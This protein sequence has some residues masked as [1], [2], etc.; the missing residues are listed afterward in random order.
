MIFC[1]NSIAIFF[2]KNNE[3][4]S[5]SKYINIKLFSMRKKIKKHKVSIKHISIELMIA[6]LMAKSLPVKK[7]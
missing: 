2:L 4:R 1:N 7:V 5:R 3:N 6:D